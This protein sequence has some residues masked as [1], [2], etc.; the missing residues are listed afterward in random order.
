MLYFPYARGR[1]WARVLG[2]QGALRLHAG[3]DSTC[4][5]ASSTDCIT[6]LALHMTHAPCRFVLRIPCVVDSPALSGYRGMR[7]PE[8]AKAVG[9]TVHAWYEPCVK[10]DS[11]QGQRDEISNLT[12]AM[13]EG[14][15]HVEFHS[16]QI[17]SWHAF[18]KEV[19]V[20]ARAPASL[21][22]IYSK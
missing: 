13:S 17:K 9:A 15:F 1:A 18:A 14:L 7:D 19:R 8:A 11:C 5:K 12:H 2:S 6:S 22:L 10:G 20:C 4:S 3:P 16:Q 21:D